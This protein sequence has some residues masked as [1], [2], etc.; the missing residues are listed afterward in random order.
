MAIRAMA[1]LA[2]SARLW[3]GI[4][5]QGQG[6]DGK[7]DDHFDDDEDEIQDDADDKSPVDLFEINGV[8]MMTEAMMIMIVGRR[9]IVCMCVGVGVRHL[10]KYYST[11]VLLLPPKKGAIY[12]TG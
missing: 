10:L 2:T 5:Q 9:L 12:A 3:P 11:K 6:M 4:R 8:M 1:R 7:A